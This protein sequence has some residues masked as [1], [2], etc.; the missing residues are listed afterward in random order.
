MLKKK[1]AVQHA[2]TLLASVGLPADFAQKYPHELSGGQLQRVVIARAAGLKPDLII[3]DECTSAL[4]VSI[5]Q[6]VI[7]LLV[8]LKKNIPFSIIFITHDLALAE[9]ICDRICVMHAGEIV[10]VIESGN[11]VRDARH[12]YTKELIQ[13][14]FPLDNMH[15]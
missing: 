9:S 13:A 1:E 7:Q 6:Q 4:D 8:D 15:Q 3:C 14:G 2:K 5:Q 11:I 12:P 10:E